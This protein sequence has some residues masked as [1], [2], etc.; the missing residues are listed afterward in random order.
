VGGASRPTKKAKRRKLLIWIG[1]SRFIN[2]WL[3][4]RL[5]ANIGVGML[6]NW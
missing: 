4:Q 3:K 1:I 6:T 5:E 2:V